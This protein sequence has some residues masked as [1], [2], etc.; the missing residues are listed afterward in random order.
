[1]DVPDIEVS[2]NGLERLSAESSFRFGI[3]IYA[4][5]LT[6]DMLSRRLWSPQ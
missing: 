1:M 3:I 2:G 4:H 6:L 5:F